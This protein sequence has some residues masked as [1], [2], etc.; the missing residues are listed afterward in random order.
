MTI[1][2]ARVRIGYQ[3]AYRAPKASPT[4][5][6]EVGVIAA[7]N[8]EH[9]FVQYGNCRPAPQLPEDLELVGPC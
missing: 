4:I 6:A 3:V 7:V 2:E 1:T 9:V 5:P 8:D